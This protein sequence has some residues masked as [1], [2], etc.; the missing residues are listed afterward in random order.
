MKKWLLGISFILIIIISFLATQAF[1]QKK[2]RVAP[3]SSDTGNLSTTLSLSPA[4]KQK[5]N[6]LEDGFNHTCMAL[7]REMDVR[8][9]CLCQEI[10]KP[11]F[12]PVATD[13]LIDEIAHYQGQMEKET[14]RH[15]IKVMKI[16]PPRQQKE[17]FSSVSSEL[18]GMCCTEETCQ[19]KRRMGRGYHNH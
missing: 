2:A 14:I 12:D 7:C 15:I 19:F 10:L 11:D 13:V 6:L 4:Q 3:S 18:K 9:L 17:F 1:Y 8:R 16:L 5:L